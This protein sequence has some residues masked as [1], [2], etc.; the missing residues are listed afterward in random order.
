[1]IK[2]ITGT[3]GASVDIQQDG[4]VLIGGTSGE[5]VSRPWP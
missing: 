5:A 4:R 2:K 1:M 3:T